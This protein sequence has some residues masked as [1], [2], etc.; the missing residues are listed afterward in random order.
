M[1]ATNSRISV[2]LVA[3]LCLAVLGGCAAGPLES[4]LNV[5]PCADGR[6]CVLIPNFAGPPTLGSR[7]RK[8]FASQ[9][10]PSMRKTNGDKDNPIT[11]DGIGRV[12]GDAGITIEEQ[13]HSDAEELARHCAPVPC[14]MTLWGESYLLGES[15][16]DDLLTS[17]LSIPSYTS[18]DWVVTTQGE[19]FSATRPA[20]RYSFRPVP[21]NKDAASIPD[22]ACDDGKLV[23]RSF[24]VIEWETRTRVKLVR[25]ANDR[26]NGEQCTVT[27]PKRP[28]DA[29]PAKFTAGVVRILRKDWCG[30]AEVM[31]DFIDDYGG[32]SLKVK[33]AAFWFLARALAE[34]AVAKASDSNLGACVT[35]YS[36]QKLTKHLKGGQVEVQKGTDSP[37]WSALAGWPTTFQALFLLHLSEY[38]AD[39]SEGLRD[40]EKVLNEYCGYRGAGDRWIADAVAGARAIGMSDEYMGAC[41][42]AYPATESL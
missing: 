13:S 24:R 20:G 36:S 41:A 8:D 14:A 37:R 23:G 17:H 25:L 22:M 5:P 33:N 12:V 21:L 29:A 15:G 35:D 1:R 3:L 10:G 31:G 2:G 40:A 32:E 19:T 39:Q 30:A 7:A 28:G 4:T 18:L 6:I 42:A 9:L 26:P 34:R 27:L 11:F 38:Q 16:R